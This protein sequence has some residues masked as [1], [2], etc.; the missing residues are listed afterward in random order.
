MQTG[1]LPATMNGRASQRL[2][3]SQSRAVAGPQTGGLT[4]RRA[5]QAGLAAVS[6]L[7][8]SQSTHPTGNTFE[9]ILNKAKVGL[10]AVLAAA[11]AVS[12]AYAAPFD[13]GTGL[14]PTGNLR[15]AG[16]VGE[17]RLD[18]LNTSAAH[19]KAG[20][21]ARKDF[22][23]KDI[24]DFLANVECT[25]GRFDTMG[26]QGQDFKPALLGE[27]GKPS[28]GLK[29]A[30]LSP[31][32]RALLEEVALSE[33]GHA[34]YT[35]QAGS[36][37]A[38]PY[39]DYDAGFNAVFA[40]AYGLPDGQTISQLFGKDWDPY[41]N[42]ATFALS[43]VFLE[44]LGATGNKGLATLHVNPILADSTAGLATTATAFAAIERSILFDLKDE[45]VP[46]TNET[47]SQVF[48]RLSAYRDSMDGP[49][50]DDQGLLNKDPRFISIP[51]SFVNNIPTDI[52]G[53]SFSRTPQMNLNIL[54]VGAKDGKGGFFP[55]GIQGRI[56]TPEG[57]DQL[58]DG[59]EDFNGQSEARQLPVADI[60]KIPGPITPEGPKKV[61]GQDS[62]TQEL[63]SGAPLVNEKP[64]T[65]GL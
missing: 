20:L 7:H 4:S 34:L 62:L 58:G 12:S 35:R 22:T 16:K 1:Q 48:A 60:K 63:N 27:G 38:C 30:K 25:E 47:V 18:D 31:R 24:I 26:V 32:T 11:V 51:D 6:K 23:D 52:R 49:Q 55:E 3:S 2:A 40:R 9:D 43:M 28:K 29:Q 5:R 64:E 59:T 33:Q 10:S 50:L 14:A 15:S 36:T 57:F 8:V 61:P 65:R 45:I 37:I 39:V 46:P 17:Y 41:V 19:I 44:E 42:D 54:T 13:T 56:H 53:L 21:A